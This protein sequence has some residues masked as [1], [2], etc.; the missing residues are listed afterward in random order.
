M[1]NENQSLV[2]AIMHDG[3]KKIC[4]NLANEQIAIIYEIAKHE[5]E[6]MDNTDLNNEAMEAMANKDYQRIID[7]LFPGQNINFLIDF[8]IYTGE[9]WEWPFNPQGDKMQVGPYDWQ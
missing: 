8:N 4:P 5:L 6:H 7:L 9:P 1:K 2:L 3:Y